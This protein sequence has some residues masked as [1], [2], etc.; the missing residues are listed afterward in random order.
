MVF[1]GCNFFSSYMLLFD[2]ARWCLTGIMLV[3]VTVNGAA[4]SLSLDAATDRVLSYSD[5]LSAAKAGV[6]S[7]NHRA[8]SLD[9]LNYPRIGVEARVLESEKTLKVDLSDLKAT[10]SAILP[11]LNSTYGS[12]IASEIPASKVFGTHISGVQSNVTATLPLYTGG[13]IA[14]T[15]KAA[16]SGVR[17]AGAELTL[18]EQTLRTQL[19]Q[20]YFLYQF[21]VRVRD[22]R[23]E[24]RDGLKLHLSNAIASE[25]AGVIAHSQTLQARVAYDETER[26]L[27]QAESDMRS[28][29][30]A[31]T[32]ILH[33][34]APPKT[35]TPL[36]VSSR[37]LPPVRGFIDAAL[38][39][40]AQL[41][42]LGAVDDAAGEAVRIE[43]SDR[44]PQVY[45]FGKYNLAG[46]NR[47]L[48]TPDWAF[49]LGVRY[50]LFSGIDRTEAEE[51]A[52]QK[53][54]QVRAQIR[55]TRND[56]ETLV[57]RAY[58]DVGS[59][60]SRFM[61]SESAITSA[62][63][64]V[65]V[66]EASFRSGYATSVDVVD[67]RLALSRA[68]IDRAQAAYQFDDALARLLSACGEAETYSAY[69]DKADRIVQ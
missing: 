69:V 27:T 53:Q 8:N 2:V 22:V 16:K 61:L 11:L 56:L 38:E 3:F 43:G 21:S 54:M 14:A 40:H 34:N 67:A 29:G 12:V 41:A 39:K 5:A 15:Q 60:Q 47:D 6:D 51:A 52:I 46:R 10:A 19:A 1:R 64:N 37:P 31:L 26:A 36:F 49:G 63:E 23:I 44:L 55:Q 18:T 25:K 20:I 48:T 30:V 42:R 7:Q 45:V 24:V 57:T 17:Q 13:R 28:A 59:A 35:V 68:E 65:R 33:L 66:Q 9:Y 32:N 58:N 62:Q 50:D 4:Q